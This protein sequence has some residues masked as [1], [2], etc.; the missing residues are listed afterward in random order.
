MLHLASWNINGLRAVIRKGELASFLS[1]YKPDLLFLQEVK[2]KPDQIKAD[3]PGYQLILN[4][5]ARPGYSGTGALVGKNIV[6]SIKDIHYNFPK[7]IA[8][9]YSLKED[10]FGDVNSEGRVLVLEFDEL[11]LVTVYTPNSKGDLSRLKLREEQWDKAFLEYMSNLNKVKPVVFCGDLNVAHQ[12]IDLANPK[13][14]EGKHGYTKEE[15]FGFS[16][17]IAAGFVDSFRYINGDDFIKYS[18]WSHWGRARERN[19]GWRI[20]YFLVSSKLRKSIIGANIIDQQ[21][22]SDHCP[23]TLDLNTK[24]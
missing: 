24:I 17:F 9:K 10:S 15:R 11:Y 19:V 20:D 23:I 4:S 7:D 3:F 5:A 21:M 14:N 18:W 8:K 6:D 12:P 13:P 22:G 2:A 16:N 1:A